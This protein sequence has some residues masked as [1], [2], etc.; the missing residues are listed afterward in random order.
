MNNS[1]NS[2]MTA[3]LGRV[4]FGEADKPIRFETHAQDERF[5]KDH[6]PS[7]VILKIG[8]KCTI[9]YCCIPHDN[10]SNIKINLLQL[11]L[12][13][14]DQLGDFVAGKRIFCEYR[15]CGESKFFR[16]KSICSFKGDYALATISREFSSTGT[17]SPTQR[18][19]PGTNW[20]KDI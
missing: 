10:L 4:L 17:Y 9:K 2:A 8:A 7:W 14:K 20:N 12:I 11:G 18:I 13:V 1:S 15:K 16:Q 3:V 5:L 19:V 6:N